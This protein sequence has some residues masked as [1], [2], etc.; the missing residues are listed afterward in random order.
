MII[1]IVIWYDVVYK[2]NYLQRIMDFRLY[3]LLLYLFMS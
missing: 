1:G 2:V 3:K